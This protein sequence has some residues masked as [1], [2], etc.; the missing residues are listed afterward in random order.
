MKNRE[1]IIVPTHPRRLDAV[2]Y[3]QKSPFSL[4][5]DS[6]LLVSRVLLLL[7]FSELHFP[8]NTR[9]KFTPTQRLVQ[10]SN[11]FLSTAKPIYY[12]ATPRQAT[13]RRSPG[14]G[15]G[16]RSSFLRRGCPSL[17]RAGLHRV[18]IFNNGFVGR[19]T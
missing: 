5:V 13:L 16:W 2:S 8:L 12:L 7:A 1:D 11:P 15:A 17:F 10:N 19:V 6:L 3:M 18:F 9:H 14:D 4:H